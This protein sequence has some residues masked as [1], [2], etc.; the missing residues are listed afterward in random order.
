M[1]VYFLEVPFAERVQHLV[2]TYANLNQQK[3]GEAI[4]KNRE[5]T[6]KR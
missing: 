6:R 2:H 1:P 3:L 4:G 5:K